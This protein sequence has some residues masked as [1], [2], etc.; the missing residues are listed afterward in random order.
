VPD[1]TLPRSGPRSLASAPPRAPLPSIEDYLPLGMN[2]RQVADQMGIKAFD[3]ALPMEWYDDV[4]AKTGCWPQA[5]GFVWSYQRV[6][7]WGEPIPLTREA[8]ELL[9]RYEAVPARATEE[10]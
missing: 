6:K 9:A 8:A 2:T 7:I 1:H 10:T 4:F 5:Y 3:T